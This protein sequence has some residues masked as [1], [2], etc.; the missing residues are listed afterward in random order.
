MATYASLTDE[1]KQIL[2]AF[3]RNARG[4]INSYASLLAQARA[5]IAAAD[6]SGG[7]RDI[8]TSL[9]NGEV[10]PNSSGIAGAHDLTKQELAAVVGFFDEIILNSDNDADRQLFA[11]ASGPT[12][13][14]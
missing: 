14:L 4:W 9:D 10:V 11:K 1:Q 5:L 6:A 13:G 7:P 8:V 12:A 2:A 3:E